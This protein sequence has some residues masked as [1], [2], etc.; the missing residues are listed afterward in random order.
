M[1]VRPHIYIATSG[2]KLHFLKGQLPPSLRPAVLEQI[3]NFDKSVLFIFKTKLAFFIFH[4][5]V[6]MGIKG[7]WVE[8]IR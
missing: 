1:E 3:L 2:R 8:S 4:F 6:Q 5:S 7:L